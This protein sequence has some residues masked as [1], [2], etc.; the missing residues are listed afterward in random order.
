MVLLVGTNTMNAENGSR[1]R[2]HEPPECSILTV[3]ALTTILCTNV[4][5]IKTATC[6]MMPQI[7]ELI[8]YPVRCEEPMC[9]LR[10]ALVT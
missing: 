6:L 5:G 2:G 10:A 1:S 8:E 7:F 3:K 9:S 4:G